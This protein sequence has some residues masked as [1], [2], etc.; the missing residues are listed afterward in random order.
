MWKLLKEGEGPRCDERTLKDAVTFSQKESGPDRRGSGVRVSSCTPEGGGFDSRAGHTPRLQVHS[1]VG[2][3]AGGSRPMSLSLPLSRTNI[4]TGRLDWALAAGW[5]PPTAAHG[6]S[7]RGAMRTD[8]TRP[9]RHGRCMGLCPGQ[10]AVLLLNPQ[11][12]GA[13]AVT[14]EARPVPGSLAAT[15]AENTSPRDSGQGHVL[16]GVL[17]LL[18]GHSPLPPLSRSQ[19]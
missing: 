19:E 18:A 15:G 4:K 16:R 12:A 13:F 5:F 10:A 11:A 2:V 14:S 7:Q 1:P 17:R 9:R 6:Q 8:T 3:H